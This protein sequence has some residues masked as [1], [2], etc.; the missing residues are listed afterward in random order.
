MRKLDKPLS[1]EAEKKSA[2]LLLTSNSQVTEEEPST[3]QRLFRVAWG[4]IHD[5]KIG[6]IKAQGS[7]RETICHE[8]YP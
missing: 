4:L 8:V 1:M 6:R 3:D 7:S 5:I 2:L